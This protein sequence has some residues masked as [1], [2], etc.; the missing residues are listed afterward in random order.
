MTDHIWTCDLPPFFPFAENGIFV[1]K[2]E[3][4]VHDSDKTER[5]IDWAQ[6]LA[7]P[8]VADVQENSSPTQQTNRQ[9]LRNEEKR[10]SKSVAGLLAL[11]D[12]MPGAISKVV[13]E[14][15]SKQIFGVDD[16]LSESDKKS[17]LREILAR[18]LALA[19]RTVYMALVDELTA[20]LTQFN[21]SWLHGLADG[22]EEEREDVRGILLAMDFSQSWGRRGRSDVIET[23]VLTLKSRSKSTPPN[24]V[25]DTDTHTQTAPTQEEV[26]VLAESSNLERDVEN[27]P[28]VAPTPRTPCS[29]RPETTPSGD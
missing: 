11:D 12:L 3:D 4:D 16:L 7:L 26:V 24:K 18:Q 22:G 13:G 1:N 10:L 19:H 20:D 25:V 28:L 14:E 27:P 8:R 5:D 23:I 9:Q 29:D 6:K 21:N 15:E 2:L 17:R